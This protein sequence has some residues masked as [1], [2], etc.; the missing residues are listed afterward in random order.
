MTKMIQNTKKHM[1]FLFLDLLDLKSARIQL[2]Y[3]TFFAWIFGIFY[4]ATF[5]PLVRELSIIFYRQNGIKAE[6][7]NM[8]SPA[9]GTTI[10]GMLGTAFMATVAGYIMSN[11]SLYKKH[12]PDVALKQLETIKQKQEEIS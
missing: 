4:F 12:D 11:M 2:V 6:A 9:Y 10:L 5:V 1:K 3:G 8:D 7:I